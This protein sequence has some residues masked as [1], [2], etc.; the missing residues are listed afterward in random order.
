MIIPTS[1]LKWVNIVTLSIRKLLNWFETPC[2]QHSKH[3]GLLTVLQMYCPLS[4]LGL[5]TCSSFCLQ[6]SSNPQ[7]P[8]LHHALSTSLLAYLLL[9]RI[10]IFLLTISSSGKLSFFMSPGYVPVVK[11]SK[12]LSLYSHCP[13]MACPSHRLSSPTVQPRLELTCSTRSPKFAVLMACVCK[14]SVY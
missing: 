14:Q 7:R 6:S 2:T 10:F 12:L 1:F 8:A 11:K 3:S 9:F 4:P 13:V 5:H